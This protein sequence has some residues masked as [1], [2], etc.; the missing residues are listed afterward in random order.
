[1][2]RISV[3]TPWEWS[4]CPQAPASLYYLDVLILWHVPH[5]GKYSGM[6]TD[7]LN[8]HDQDRMRDQG[9]PA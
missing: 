2:L 8:N 5:G 6:D 9:I 3:G 4:T 1:M 7:R